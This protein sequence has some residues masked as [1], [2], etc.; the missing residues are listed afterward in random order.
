MKYFFIFLISI[1]S[2]ASLTGMDA[3]EQKDAPWQ[4]GKNA[5][6]REQESE[7]RK[8][9]NPLEIG[10]QIT[11]SKGWKVGVATDH[12]EAIK[13]YEKDIQ[14]LKKSLKFWASPKN[15]QQ[16]L[17]KLDKSEMKDVW[18]EHAPLILG[19]AQTAVVHLEEVLRQLVQNHDACDGVK[20]NYARAYANKLI[21]KRFDD[22]KMR[23]WFS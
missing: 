8:S 15:I 1:A 12:E 10:S 13:E 6:L 9:A 17:K 23:E 18:I 11:S 22:L 20:E 14:A 4:L 19:Y 7:A 21:L 2:L 16:H 5:H 3:G